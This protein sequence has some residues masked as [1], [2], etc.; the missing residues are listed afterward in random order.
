MQIIASEVNRLLIEL[1]V[2]KA[3]LRQLHY[4]ILLLSTFLS[5]KVYFN[6]ASWIYHPYY[7][8][9]VTLYLRF[10]LMSV[11]ELPLS[12]PYLSQN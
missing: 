9:G 2:V 12:Q 1:V 6:G 5:S 3:L 7:T 8:E 4:Y 11:R 10:I